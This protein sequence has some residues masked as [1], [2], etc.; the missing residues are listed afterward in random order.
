[1]ENCKYDKYCGGCSLLA[2]EYD[3]QL[4]LKTEEVKKIFQKNDICC[5]IPTTC[6]MF[7]PYRYRNKIH[8]AFKKLK[9]KTLVGFF[10]EG[11]SKITDIDDCLLQGKWVSKLVSIVKSY[12][13]KYKIEPYDNITKSG[14]L[15]YVV[16]RVIDDS[17]MLTV[18]ATTRNFPGREYLYAK[19]CDNFKKVSFY[20]N[21]NKR[22]DKLVFDNNNMFFV[23]GEKYIGSSML[24]VKYNI[25]PNSF[26][27]VNLEICKMMYQKAIELLDLNT[28]DNVL[29]LY[30]GIGITT[31]L[32]AKKCKSVLSIEY[33]TDATKM[34]EKN[35]KLNDINNV[36]ILTGEC[37]KVLQKIDVKKYN[38]IFLDPA[39]LGMENETIS[40]ILDSD[41]KRI[42]Y[43]SCD[44]N[45]LARD[46]AKLLV[47][48]EIKYIQ[49]YDMF[50]HTN[51]VETLVCLDKK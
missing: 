13:S 12:V 26:L 2:V 24:G 31:M 37:G 3:K 39:R 48:Y 45:T 23:K 43:M 46:V 10:E 33:G 17:I 27:Q 28:D 21:V 34:A 51:H 5:D 35:A 25:A 20:I 16:A 7:F 19:L 49:T 11:S 9:G 50:P 4:Q 22:T 6:G 41:A 32:F 29:D 42:V 44:P 8:L 30:S 38:K 40:R 18:V 14:I 36:E 15:R 1:M 47:K